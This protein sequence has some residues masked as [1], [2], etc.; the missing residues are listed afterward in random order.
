MPYSK[1]TFS[2]KKVF[3]PKLDQPDRLLCPWVLLLQSIWRRVLGS[4]PSTAIQS[5][6]CLNT[7]CKFSKIAPPPPPPPPPHTHTRSFTVTTMMQFASMPLGLVS[8]KPS[9]VFPSTYS[10]KLSFFQIEGRGICIRQIEYLSKCPLSHFCLKVVFK[11]GWSSLPQLEQ[12]KRW[13]WLVKI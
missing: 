5:K 7:Y 2:H 10:E 3:R 13:Q 6:L 12:Q 8:T 11:K 1:W 9:L 4:S